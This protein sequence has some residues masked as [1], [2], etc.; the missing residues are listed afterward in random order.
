MLQIL[1]DVF[2]LIC[3]QNPDHTWSP[4][5]LLLPACQRCTGLYIG[6]FVAALWHIAFRPAPTNRWL[7]LHGGF[8]LA[9]VPF[10]F[11]LV[12]QGPFVRTDSGVLFGFGL[13]AFLW[14]TLEPAG[15]LPRSALRTAGWCFAASLVATVV[16]IPWFGA[17][18]D[19]TA[20]VSLSFLIGAG[21]FALT[22]LV[23]WNLLLA[24]MA[25]I[26]PLQ[27]LS[28]RGIA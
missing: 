19:V 4:G 9:M 26:R 6:A 13:V 18:G 3:H 11:H 2:G 10:G 17:S 8:L 22:A 25:I 20:A 1:N 7:W 12:P 15:H 24:A 14:L 16:L 5:G 23:T 27:R 21:A 28:Q